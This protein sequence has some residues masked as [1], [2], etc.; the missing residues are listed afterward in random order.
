MNTYFISIQRQFVP[1]DQDIHSN[2]LVLL[3]NGTLLVSTEYDSSII[4]N[5]LTIANLTRISIDPSE[6]E[7]KNIY[8]SSLI[9]FQTQSYLEQNKYAIYTDTLEYHKQPMFNSTYKTKFTKILKNKTNQSIVCCLTNN[10]NIL[11]YSYMDGNNNSMTFLQNLTYK[12]KEVDADNIDIDELSFDLY[13]D[14]EFDY[15]NEF[16]A[17]SNR[18]GDLLIFKYSPQLQRFEYLTSVDNI[19]TEKDDDYVVQLRC[20]KSDFLNELKF[21]AKSYRNEVYLVTINTEDSTQSSFIN[22]CIKHKDFMISDFIKLDGSCFY[23]ISANKLYNQSNEELYTFENYDTKKILYLAKK[24]QLIIY[25]L[26]E[27]VLFDV[28]SNKAIK[29]PITRFL[30]KKFSASKLDNPKLSLNIHGID[31]AN[32]ESFIAIAYSFSVTF[33]ITYNRKSCRELCVTFF[34]I[35]DNWTMINQQHVDSLKLWYFQYKFFGDKHAIN[36]SDLLDQ[37]KVSSTQNVNDAL[38]QKPFDEFIQRCVLDDA[39]FGIH[40]YAF[41]T[42]EDSVYESALYSKIMH[43]LYEYAGHHIDEFE[44]DLDIFSINLIAKKLGKPCLFSKTRINEITM[45]GEFID[46]TFDLE[47]CYNNN[48]LVS[49]EGHEWKSCFLTQLP[50]LSTH[51][52]CCKMVNSYIIDIKKDEHLNEY[53]WFTSTLLSKLASKCVVTGMAYV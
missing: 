53:G 3:N 16:L 11:V 37:E 32:D 44:N 9:N 18:N 8:K 51:T 19:C 31:I 24:T 1:V 21:V 7:F 43:L 17:V 50:I 20:V 25:S 4:P 45:K 27:Y 2:N 49:K 28:A 40:K 12:R 23:Y 10:Y 36:Y 6:S 14:M 42:N 15:T 29:S 30:I 22:I 41:L 38:F 47:N 35:D 48:H 26:N 46:E 34:K 5:D 39:F 52:K 33:G 13:Y